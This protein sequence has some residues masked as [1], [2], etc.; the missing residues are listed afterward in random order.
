VPATGQSQRGHSVGA[1]RV[2]GRAGQQQGRDDPPFVA[3]DRVHQ[4]GPATL[5]TG[6]H[7]GAGLQ[8]HVDRRVVSSPGGDDDRRCAVG[9]PL[10]GIRAVRQE[11]TLPSGRPSG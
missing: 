3:F 7:V 8:E 10:V 2:D 9:A 5:V 4:R 6:F 1:D 11:K